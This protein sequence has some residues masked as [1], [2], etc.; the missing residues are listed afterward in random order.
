MV[1]S[2]VLVMVVNLKAVVGGG[3]CCGGVGDNGDDCGGDSLQ[4]H[5]L[6][7]C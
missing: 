1:I 2:Y 3:D 7:F 5:L 6:T 4:L